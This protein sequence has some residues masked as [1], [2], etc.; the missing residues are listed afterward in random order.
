[1]SAQLHFWLNNEEIRCNEPPGLLVLDYLRKKQRLVGTKEGCKEGDCG[2]CTVL[3]GE[4]QGDDVVY[5]PVTSCLMPVGELHG[6]HL[7]T[8]EGLNLPYLNP[9]QKAIVEEGATQCGFCTPG[10]V[11]SLTGYLMQTDQ[12]ITA[13]GVKRWLSGHLCRCTGY[14]SLKDAYLHLKKIV[15]EHTGV[16]ELVKHGW[17]PA[18]FLE[19]PERLRRIPPPVSRDGRSEERL[20]IAGGT[21]IYVQ[22]GEMLPEASVHIL[23]RYPRMKGIR[24]AGRFLRIGALTTFEEL[25]NHPEVQ[26][27][28]PR[29]QEYMFLVASLQIRNRATIGGNI[30]NAS[31]IADGVILLLA[32]DAEVVMQKGRQ[33]RVIP[34][35]KLYRGYKQLDKQPGE[36]LTEVRLPLS[37]GKCQIHFEKVSKRRTLDIA[38]VNSAIRLRCDAAGIIREAALAVGGVAPIPLY[39]EKTSRFLVGRPC[40]P[41]TVE[42][43][44][45]QAMEEISPISDIRGSADYKRLL[46]RQLI[47]AHFTELFP[48]K[49][50]VRD[51]YA[52]P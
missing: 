44:I 18:Y 47:I 10:I 15:G 9:V 50:Q 42:G 23:N 11:V 46:T 1:M 26:K 31:P 6:K 45:E 37:V 2:A 24:R 43:A 4:L 3:V 39:L 8:I 34:L 7:V 36:I 27:L 28:V 33:Q 51:Y 25:G 14:R 30:I 20:I 5:R 12:P 41:E 13:D 52:I 49:M 19:M 29:I 32:L 16:E 35:R 40:T 17:L 48:E 38:S 21:D 22:R